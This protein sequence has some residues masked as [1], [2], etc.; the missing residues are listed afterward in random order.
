MTASSKNISP[1]ISSDI[2]RALREVSDVARPLNI[3]FFVL[4]A[5]ARDL[6]FGAYHDI[7]APRATLDIDLAL[8]VADWDQYARLRADLLG[9]GHYDGDR[10][11]RQRLIHTTGVLIDLVPFG[12][13]E[14]GDHGVAWPPEQ[15]VVMH[16]TGFEEALASAITMTIG[17]DPPCVIRVCT[18]AALAAMK[19]IAWEERYPERRKDA[20]DLLFL[21][22]QYV[23]AGNADRLYTTEK[24]LFAGVGFSFEDAS[25]RLLGSDIRR[26]V[27]P[28]TRRALLAIIDAE[29]AA[30]SQ[31]RLVSDMTVAGLR[32]DTTVAG[33]LHLLDQLKQGLMS[34]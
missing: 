6:V 5:T 14:T 23:H 2:A 1:N 4:G 11:H 19:I 27:S 12:P 10:H 20:Q 33:V 31:F 30:D 29:T 13:V 15:D 28:A 9:T 8:R 3:P 24:Q 22:K 7:P 25:P 32:D 26:I 16:T 17:E 34:G 18:P 21:M